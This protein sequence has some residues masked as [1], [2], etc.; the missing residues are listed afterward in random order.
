MDSRVVKYKRSSGDRYAGNRGWDWYWLVGLSLGK[1]LWALGFEMGK[2]PVGP[3]M[4]AT[5]VGLGL[6]CCVW[7]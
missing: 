3:V 4:L 7:S 2:G 5:T 1:E 6:K